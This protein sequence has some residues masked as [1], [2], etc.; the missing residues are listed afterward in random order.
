MQRLRIPVAAL[1][2]AAL[3]L[4]APGVGAEEDPGG[5]GVVGGALVGAELVVI[6]EALFGVKPTWAYFVGGALGGGAGAYAGHIVEQE[7][8][9]EV[10]IIVLAAGVGLVIPTLVW[11]GNARQ[12]TP[13][14]TDGARWL[15]PR[16]SVAF[17]PSRRVP[18]VTLDV[19]RGEF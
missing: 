8:R 16:A 14:P 12:P 2:F 1:V 13:A 6:G 17:D 9:S 5:R 10:S 19:V 18:S 15:P 3:G 11:V 4:L 7:T